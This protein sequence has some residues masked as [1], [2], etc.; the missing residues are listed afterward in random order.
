VQLLLDSS[1]PAS[2]AGRGHAGVSLSRL[3][4]QEL[5]DVELLGWA[6]QRHF[7][8]VVLMGS[9]ALARRQLLDAAGSM[10]MGLVIVQS[11]NPVQAERHLD[12]ALSEVSRLL[13]PGL[14]VLV[15]SQG[16]EVAS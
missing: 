4:N 11:S 12:G 10:A 14:V 5:S 15:T 16:A 7:S 3:E 2:A 9:S 1:F 6:Q 8:G 13:R